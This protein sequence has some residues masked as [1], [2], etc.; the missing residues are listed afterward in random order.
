[1]IKKI[2]TQI[3][4]HNL[5]ALICMV[6]E[7]VNNNLEVLGVTKVTIKD[8]NKIKKEHNKKNTS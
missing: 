6:E 7:I 3:K 8:M 2:V 4:I 5:S 1:M